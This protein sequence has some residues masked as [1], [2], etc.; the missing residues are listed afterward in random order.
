MNPHFALLLICFIH[1]IT[2]FEGNADRRWHTEYFLPKEEI[3][4]YNILID[5]IKPLDQPIRNKLKTYEKNR[6]IT[7]GQGDDYTTG[8][9]LDYRYFKKNHKLIVIH[10]TS[11]E[12]LIPIKKQHKLIWWKP[13]NYSNVIVWKYNNVICSWGS[14]R[15]YFWLF[16]RNNNSIVSVFYKFILLLYKINIKMLQYFS[17]NVKLCNSKFNKLKSATNNETGTIL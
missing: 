3:K 1:S 15:N 2:L 8:Y 17:L 14:K 10:L 7:T 6:K 12:H 11:N 9:L 13:E 5:W 16:R 4:G